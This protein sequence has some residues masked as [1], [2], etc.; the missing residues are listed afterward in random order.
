MANF[1]FVKTATAAVLGASVLTTAVLPGTDA[2]A[3]TTYKVN[4]N[5]TLVN[6][7]TNKAV[8]GYKSYK[9]ILYKNGKK[10]TGKT[11]AGY[12]YVKGKRF[13]GKTKYGYYYKNGKRFTGTT[14]YGYYYKDGKRFNGTTKYGNLYVD[15]KRADG[16][17][18]GKVYN[19]GKK[20]TGVFKDKF[21]KNGVLNVGLYLHNGILYEGSALNEGKDL[22]KDAL[23]DGST[24]NKG[25]AVF[26]G[27]LY[28]D[29]ALAKG[30]VTYDEKLYNEG[31][32]F[33]GEK[34]GVEYKDGV[35]VKYEVTAVKAINANELQ[36]TYAQPV[37]NAS[38]P[39]YYEVTLNGTKIQ[40]TSTN[41]DILVSEDK[42]T[43]TIRL[44]GASFP[45]FKAGDKISAQVSDGVVTVKGKKIERYASETFAFESVAPKLISASAKSTSSAVTLTFDQPVVT[46][47]DS[48]LIKIDGF[49]VAKGLGKLVAVAPTT[50]GSYSYTVS[51]AG[52]TDVQ[53]KAVLKEGAH[54]VALFDVA[55]TAS[56]NA[57]V[58]P[59]LNVNYTIS[60]AESAPKVT[61][62]QPINANKFFITFD[63]VIKNDSFKLEVSKGTLA[64]KT[65][66]TQLLADAAGADLPDNSTAYVQKGVYNGETG[67]YVAVTDTFPTDV[68]PL[69][70]DLEKS[71]T[72]NVKVSEFQ[73]ASGLL[74][75]V[76][77]QALTLSKDSI[78]P[79]V[80]N[81]DLATDGS[82]ITLTFDQALNNATF[83]ASKVVL[84]D[85]DGVILKQGATEAYTVSQTG[86][87]VTLTAKAGTKFDKEPYTVEFAKEAAQYAVNK[88]TVTDYSLVATKNDAFTV[89]VGKSAADNTKYYA[90]GSANRISVVG[91]NKILV[92]F[93]TKMDAATVKNIKNYKLDGVDLTGAT[94]DFYGDT[95]HVLITFPEGT[96]KQSATYRLT[97]AKDVLTEAKQQ[98]V[99]DAQSLDTYVGTF[100]ATDNASPTITG[101]KFYVA[102]E[103]YT[104]V[105]TTKKIQLTFNE[106]VALASDA[107]EDDDVK[108][109]INGQVFDGTLEVSAT[110]KSVVYFTT[111]KDIN[112]N[113]S[114]TIKVLAEADQKDTT[115]GIKDLA[116]NKAAAG[117]IA[118]SG[119]AIDASAAKDL[120]DAAELAAAKSNLN[121]A[122]TT[123]TAASTGKTEGSVVGNQIVG[124]GATLTAAIAVAQGVFDNASATV[125]QVNNAK[126]TLD[127]AVTAYND[128][129]VVAYT[130]GLSAVSITGTATDSTTALTLAAD[131]TLAV[132]SSDSAKATAAV[133]G[134]DATKVDITGVAAGT[135]T[136]TINVKNA[137]GNVIKVATVAVT[138]N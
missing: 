41:S 52:L 136:I 23:Y 72:V 117:E 46:A 81:K 83:D 58:A 37:A 95:Q 126:T 15:G 16:L 94:I 14:K 39:E 113:E 89:S 36:V 129:K 50:P 107:A 85:A 63:Q 99:K 119:K 101:A 35:V 103:D 61:S 10:F 57:A 66:A 25:L 133:N 33:T 40:L 123:A 11:K 80:I 82:K 48:S 29:S 20:Y 134:A 67:Y 51:L 73:S 79:T 49:E 9:G 74:G 90:L 128:A 31:S 22:Y 120:Q 98:V 104:K 75:T 8:N 118:V 43:A 105:P 6:A 69:Y 110:D 65:D 91:T 70:K 137:A 77:N 100:S 53:K 5:G 102:S 112:V 19:N 109:V 34:D 138:V 54:Q 27:K 116:G 121:S 111:T 60:N 44:K 127:S 115:A 86:A 132:S 24:P 114:A 124:S 78:K 130:P 4:K 76:Y 12:Y 30:Y 131:E 13:T 92:D 55:N 17:Y 71:A 59:V 97:I 135:A 45:G 18:K 122:I 32:L 2:S 93:G 7:K 38:T 3:K 125:T 26:E 84:K 56:S 1:K 108:L 28:S 106:E 68:N 42:T 88:S 47:N 96:F 87:T 21:Y 64:F 62:V